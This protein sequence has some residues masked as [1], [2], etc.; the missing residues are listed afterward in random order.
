MVPLIGKKGT[1]GA[2]A[3]DNRRGGTHFSGDDQTLLEGLGNQAVIAIE[4]ARLVDDLRRSREQ[5]L[6]ADRLGTLGTLA[7]GLAHE[8]NNPLV[9]IH[10]FLS[11]APG[12]RNENDT[13]FWTDYHALACARGRSHPTARRDDAPARPRQRAGHAARGH[14]SRRARAGGRHA[15]P[16]AR[17]AKATSR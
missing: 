8:I 5:V 17:R 6:R 13:E 3:I 12:K 11:M 9:S 16:A 15:A 4:N 2:L 14:G 1:I 10:T 7:A